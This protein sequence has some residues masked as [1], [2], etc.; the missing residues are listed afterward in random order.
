M[1]DTDYGWVEVDRV[2]VVLFFQ[3]TRTAKAINNQL[4]PPPAT[5]SDYAT[6]VVNV[7]RDAV[8]QDSPPKTSA[9]SG[10]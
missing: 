5:E 3:R 10:R 2:A 4:S 9:H 8:A 7:E 6:D 1:F